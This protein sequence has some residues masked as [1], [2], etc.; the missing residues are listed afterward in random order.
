MTRTCDPLVPNQMRYQLRHTP[1]RGCK[2]SKTGAKIK[3]NVAIFAEHMKQAINIPDTGSLNCGAAEFLKKT[4]GRKL[5]ALHGPMG[6]GKTTFTSAICHELGVKD[7][8]VGS[9]TF[10]IVNEYRDARGESIFHFDFYRINRLSEALD[11]GLYDY[12]DSGCLCIME[13]PENIAPLLP[14][15]TLDVE[16]SV[17]PDGCRT[18]SWEDA[19]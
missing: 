18:I 17:G 16:I 13:W 12:L 6:A 4:A 3:I 2:Y 5:I 19:L 8:A 11:I 14:E 7:D 1:K 15:D 10:S 9:P